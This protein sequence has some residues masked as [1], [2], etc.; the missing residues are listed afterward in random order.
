MNASIWPVMLVLISWPSS[1]KKCWRN[2]PLIYVFPLVQLGTA[3]WKWKQWMDVSYGCFFNSS[4]TKVQFL[5]CFSNHNSLTRNIFFKRTLSKRQGA[6]KNHILLTN[7]N[8]NC[9]CI[10]VDATIFFRWF[11]H[12]FNHN[13]TTLI[14]FGRHLMAT[15]TIPFVHA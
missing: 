9:K 13:S 10:V 15:D 2:D 5:L 12:N 6:K 3:D 11:S 7:N 14:T 4:G 1:L 8:N